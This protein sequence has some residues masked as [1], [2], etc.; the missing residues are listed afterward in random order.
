[1]IHKLPKNEVVGLLEGIFFVIGIGVILYFSLNSEM[2]LLEALG[3]NNSNITVFLALT[4]IIIGLLILT[5]AG[6]TSSDDLA[7]IC[8][9][10]YYSKQKK[11]DSS[12]ESS[13]KD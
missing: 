12:D 9:R 10:L 3:I 13:T 5:V 11:L 6:S 4:I 2:L 1:M 8:D 7:Q